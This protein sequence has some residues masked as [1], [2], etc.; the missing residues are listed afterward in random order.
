MMRT[1]TICAI[2]LSWCVF[3]ADGELPIRLGFD[4]DADAL[5]P[6]RADK[7]A[8]DKAVSK[9]RE[10][11]LFFRLSVA[12][13]LADKVESDRRVKT[14]L[15]NY[16]WEHGTTDLNLISG[17]SAWAIEK[18]LGIEVPPISKDTGD[19]E[20]LRI[21]VGVKQQLTAFSKGVLAIL[22]AQKKD[23]PVNEL[24]K[25]YG[26]LRLG[27]SNKKATGSVLDAR[28]SLEDFLKLLNE[29]FP[30]GRSVSDLETIVGVEGEKFEKGIMYEFETGGT[31]CMCHVYVKD[32]KIEAILFDVAP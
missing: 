2:S 17:R 9:L 20:R 27:I 26:D 24:V 6:R 7:Q 19:E 1:L 12:I 11:P 4:A 14:A 3:G 5:F 18:L 29:W 32:S 21:S 30:I 31:G 15:D 22:E 10:L 23:P 16:Q 25:R 8:V 28:K 13:K